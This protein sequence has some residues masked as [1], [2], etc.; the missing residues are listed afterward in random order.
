MKAVPIENRCN[1]EIIAGLAK[2]FKT[3]RDLIKILNGHQSKRKYIQIG[4]IVY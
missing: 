1:N 2:H 4:V 3:K